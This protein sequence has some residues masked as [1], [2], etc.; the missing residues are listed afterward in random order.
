M[1]PTIRV[2]IA[3]MAFTLEQ[4]AYKMVDDYLQALRAHF[5]NKPDADEII[6][7]IEFRMSEL[8]QMRSKANNVVTLSDVQEIISIMGNPKDFGDEAVGTEYASDGEEDKDKS[9]LDSLRK[10]KL[11]RDA[12]NKVLGGVCS[13]LGHYFKIDPVVFRLIFVVPML[14][15]VFFSIFDFHVFHIGPAKVWW[16]FLLLYVILW[17]VMPKARSFKDKLVM[18]G[19]NPSI[20]DIENRAY[21]ATSQKYRGSILRDIVIGFFNLIVAAMGIVACITLIA[22]VIVF[23][24]SLVSFNAWELDSLLSVVGFESSIDI[25]IMAFLACILPLIGICYLAFKILKRS[26]FTSGDFIISIVAFC[27]WIGISAYLLSVGVTFF[28]DF[29]IHM[30]DIQVIP[31]SSQSDVLYLN[32]DN[33]YLDGNEFFDSKELFFLGDNKKDPQLFT[34]PHISTKVDTTLANIKVEVYKRAYG[35]TRASAVRTAKK[36]NLDYVLTDS[37]LTISPKIYS[38][39]SPWH[40]ETFDITISMPAGKKVKLDQSLKETFWRYSYFDDDSDDN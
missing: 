32:I 2:S 39:S 23:V 28:K 18:K 20:E 3:G 6:A 38:R 15:P 19:T 8:F 29:K 12:D 25:K 10:K 7:D 11:Y 4:D 27:T 5:S 40:G 35:R 33:K 34:I 37:L 21:S 13:G 14:F 26:R 1:E 24:F 22:I 17:V 9:V 31:I 16:T 30:S 36:A